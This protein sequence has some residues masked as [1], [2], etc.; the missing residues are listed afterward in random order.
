VVV[1]DAPKTAPV[2]AAAPDQAARQH[3]TEQVAG[4]VALAFLV[5]I[6]VMANYLA[7]RHYTRLDWTTQGIYTLSAKSKSVL[8]AVDEPLDLYLFL[9]RSEPNFEPTDE[10][11][12]RYQAVSTQLRVHYV[13]PDREPAEFKILAQRFG[14]AAGVIETGQ[15]MADV[16]AV[17]ARGDKNWHVNREDLIGFE[18]GPMGGAG[19]DESVNIMAEQAL[20]G[21]IVQV[22][23]GRPTVVC[24]TEGHGE[25]GL[26]GG[27]ER[28]LAPLVEGL[29]HD[30]LEW[31]A[32][33]TVGKEKLGEGCDAVVVAGPM[34]P[35]S[36]AEARALGQYLKAGGSVLLALD[37]VIENDQVKPTGFEELALGFGVRVDRSLVL[38][39]DKERLRTPNPVEFM[40]TEFGDHDTTRALRDSAVAYMLL[41]RSVAPT[42]SNDSAEILLRTSEQAFGELEVAQVMGDLEPTK[43]P[44]DIA[45]PVPLAVAVRVNV[46]PDKPV[47]GKPGG[48]LVVVG[49]SDWL[50]GALLQVP[51][52][53]NFHLA[54][55]WLGWL[56]EREALIQIPPKKIKRGNIVFTQ[57]DLWALLL[58]VGILLPGAALLFGVAVWINRRA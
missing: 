35:F 55:A 37:P 54:S 38:E 4:L 42:G 9:S 22:T 6:A 51:D 23:S 13:D 50:E 3:T 8:A 17:V 21:A 10:L 33:A 48:R 44:G 58:R 16:A 53:A 20:T 30:N 41:A 26:D 47:D 14:I 27:A 43:S 40:V 36:E 32:L 24:V 52:L 1:S 45:G 7:F 49:D 28:S 15:A 31:K 56:G 2:A 46:N 29:R 12:K 34:T 19:E 57:D 5:A 11:L 39:L 18:M 25:R